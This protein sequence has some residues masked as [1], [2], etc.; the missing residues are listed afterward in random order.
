MHMESLT[1]EASLC[2]KCLYPHM[3]ILSIVFYYTYL[4]LGLEINSTLFGMDQFYLFWILKKSFTFTWLWNCFFSHYITMVAPKLMP[5]LLLCWHTMSEVDVGDEAVGVEPSHQYSNKFCCR[6]TDDS[7]GAVWHNGIWHGRVYGAKV[8]NWIPPCGK[9]Y[10][11]W[12]SSTLAEH[13]QRPNS[14][15]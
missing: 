12:Y 9:N 15:C 6:T 8:C 7:R 4:K 14:E 11:Q 13:L 1:P 5:P 3:F 2:F 10:T